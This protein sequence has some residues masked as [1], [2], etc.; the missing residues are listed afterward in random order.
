MHTYL[1]ISSFK[2]STDQ[3][4][5][6]QVAENYWEEDHNFHRDTKK[7]ED[8]ESRFISKKVEECILIYS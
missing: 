2:V 6:E 3:L 8:K 7:V 4:E 5:T 1:F